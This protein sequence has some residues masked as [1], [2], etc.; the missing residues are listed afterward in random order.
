MALDASAGAE[1][2]PASAPLSVA[3]TV[4]TDGDGDGAKEIDGSGR[5]GRHSC[6]RYGENGGTQEFRIRP[7]LYQVRTNVG[8]SPAPINLFCLPALELKQPL[9]TN[10]RAEIPSRRWLS[11]R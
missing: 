2:P 3:G 9:D 6:E 7:T 10:S 4:N 5:F 8:A 11:W 1:T